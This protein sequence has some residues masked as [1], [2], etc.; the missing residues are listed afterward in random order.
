[1]FIQTV[2]RALD[3]HRV[4]YALVGGYAV[5]LH[6]AIRGTVD[7]DIAIALNRATFKRIETALH[8]IGLE[9][10]LPVTAEEVFAF[11]AEYIQSRN[12]KAW[13]FANPRNPLEVVDILITE[14]AK[15]INTV[16]KRAFGMIVKVA[17]IADLI[18]IKKKA[19]RA[20]D[21]EDI[22]ALRKLT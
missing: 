12:L 1:M 10:R 20:Q 17:A 3:K 5:A 16:N 9:S 21:L 18:A 15:R 13:S 7:V 2:I 4:K 11:R 19:G 6:G 8:E 14:D 22:K